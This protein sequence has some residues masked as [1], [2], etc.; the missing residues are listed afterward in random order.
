MESSIWK[1]TQ[2][3]RKRSG[4]IYKSES[5]DSILDYLR[6]NKTA[7]I[8]ELG[9]VTGKPTTEVRTQ[10]RQLDRQG[11]VEQIGGG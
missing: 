9:S 5:S 10:L 6:E 8:E 4:S 1:L 11:L 2:L 7:S 3:G